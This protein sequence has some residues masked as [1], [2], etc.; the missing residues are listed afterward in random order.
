MSSSSW[1][2]PCTFFNTA[3]GCRNGDR[4]TFLHDLTVS[5]QQ[6]SHGSQHSYSARARSDDFQTWSYDVP[7]DSSAPRLGPD[8][9]RFLEKAHNLVRQ[10]AEKMQAVITRLSSEGGLHRINEIVHNI[11]QTLEN[12]IS[13]QITL[14]RTQLLRLFQILSNRDVQAS[15]IV[16]NS[17]DTIANFLFGFAGRRSLTIFSFV[18]RTLSE[19]PVAIGTKESASAL[20]T[21]STV[22]CKVMDLNGS[23]VIT[24]GFQP[25]L[26]SFVAC[27]AELDDNVER[28]S[29]TS[30]RLALE[31]VHRR[32]GIGKALPEAKAVQKA[33][34]AQPTF[35]LYHDAP[36]WLS[37]QGPR[38]DNDFERI[39][40]IQIMPTALE[41]RSHRVEYLPVMEA[42]QLHLAGAPGLLDRQFR[43]LREDTVGSLRDAVRN[44][45]NSTGDHQQAA[46]TYVYHNAELYDLSFHKFRGLDLKYGFEQPIEVRTLDAEKRRAWWLASRRLQFGA[47]VCL[48]D[49]QGSP[50]FC[51]VSDTGLKDDSAS[52]KRTTG[53][54]PDN[55]FGNSQWAVVTLSLVE[56]NQGTLNRLLSGFVTGHGRGYEMLIEFPG[57]LLPSFEPTLRALQRYSQAAE[58][59]PFADLLA[60]VSGNPKHLHQIDPP[61]Y[62]LEGSFQFDLSCILSEGHALSLSP[63]EYFDMQTL[64]KHSSLDE[65]QAGSLVAALSRKFALIQGPPGTGKSYT[66]VAIIK[67]LLANRSKAQ[68]GPIICVCNTNHAIDQV[69]EHLIDNGVNQVIRIGSRS[70]SEVLE[71]LNLKLVARELQQTQTEK[72]AWWES[73]NE[74]EQIL[75]STNKILQEYSHAERPENISLYLEIN[76]RAQ[77]KELFGGDLVDEEGFKEIHRRSR[78]PLQDWLN[79][80]YRGTNRLAHNTRTVD[81]LQRSSLHSMIYAER[82]LIYDHWVQGIR[83][84]LKVQIESAL[85]QYLETRNQSNKVSREVE[86]RC[87]QQA[88]VVGVTTSGLARVMDLLERLKSKV[89]I[90]EEAAEVLEAHN[91]ASFPPSVEHAILIGDHLQLRPQIQNFGLSSE[92]THGKQFSLDVSLFERLV[93]PLTETALRVPF[94]TLGIQRRMHPS[95]SMLVRSTCYPQLKDAYN[96]AEYPEVAGMRRRLFWFDHEHVEAGQD[97]DSDSLIATSHSNDFEVKI[98]AA[99]VSHLLKQG[100]YLSQDIAVLTPYLG[101]LRKLRQELSQTFVVIVGERDL[102]K[103]EAIEHGQDVSIQAAPLLTKTTLLNSMRVAKVDN[104]QGEEAKVV[105][106]SLVRCNNQNKCGFLRTPNRINVLLSRA[107]HGMYIIG[108]ARTSSH[109]EMWSTVI[110]ILHENGNFGQTLELECPRHPDIDIRIRTPDD[111]VVFAP[112]GGCNLKCNQRLSCGHACVSR[113]HSD[114]LH[115]AV[116]CLESCSRQ[117][118]GCKVHPCPEICGEPCPTKC[119]VTLHNISLPC[120]HTVQDLPC[121]EAQDLDK[122]Q[123][124][125][126][127]TWV[128]CS[129]EHIIQIPCYKRRNA[130]SIECTAQCG[131]YL[132]CGHICKRSCSQCWT[133]DDN[134]VVTIEHGSCQQPC[135]RPSTT[136]KHYCKAVCHGQAACPLCE[137]PCEVRC[138]HS[139]C[140][141]KCH[142]PCPP[143]AEERCASRC[144][145]QSCEMPC[146]VP[147]NWIPCSKRCENSLA[148]GHQCPSLCGEVCPTEAYCQICCSDTIKELQV[149]FIMGESYDEIDLNE[150][151]VILPRCGH[152]VTRSNMDGI[153][154]MGRH[155]DI[156]EDGRVLAI[157]SASLPFSSEDMHT[158]P[159]CRGSLRDLSRYGRI[160]R[161]ALLDEAS[162]RFLVWAENEYIH[163][164][165]SLC[166][167]KD[168]LS[169]IEVK[170]TIQ[171]PLQ[172]KGSRNDQFRTLLRLPLF[173]EEN[174]NAMQLRRNILRFVERVRKEELPYQKVRDMVDNIRRRKGV[175]VDL[176]GDVVTVKMQH[177]LKATSLLIQCDLA[178]LSAA[179]KLKQTSRGA[180][181]LVQVAAE[182]FIIDLTINRQDC[183]DL[184]AAAVTADLP[185]HQVEGHLLFAQFAALESSVADISKGHEASYDAHPE[186]AEPRQRTPDGTE[187][188]YEA[189]PHLEAAEQLCKKYPKATSGMPEE[190]Q[191][192]AK[193]LR[194]AFYENVTSEERRQVLAAMN[195]ELRGT[196]HWQV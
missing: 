72:R 144:P 146:G 194:G 130:K 74:M 40:Q 105:I 106:V 83:S 193:M 64:L 103:L 46:R 127:I 111:F 55:V 30:A 102:S 104:F 1:K 159:T 190:L 76:N 4:C 166:L 156:D 37:E 67:V 183:N 93:A 150:D 192:A 13:T 184:V 80:G 180:N 21:C 53:K 168:Q 92:N 196:G 181:P 122:A 94:S 42:S 125:H 120:G 17:L 141:R 68:L 35:K 38:H 136:C 115:Q 63:G 10:D 110:S 19:L 101:Q 49:S 112:E 175:V 15:L 135:D 123:C 161:R 124:T 157:K 79:H 174:R 117:V 109:V 7:R 56:L 91:I 153:L 134:E 65:A 47:L 81:E 73:K 139:T 5:N 52:D 32:L 82:R 6:P 176:P 167:E 20:E 34:S 133:T 62:C 3:R 28:L 24:E 98:T 33:R 113:C 27:L 84:K 129:C 8:L 186:S 14:F 59:L 126:P 149:D 154:D 97:G 182:D 88:H 148:C 121:H 137:S 48:L 60:P 128:L 2:R 165:E 195:T 188:R 116:R 87:L 114:T 77:F 57:V 95:I 162:K 138:I 160:V 51:S 26:K 44:I 132:P 96:V 75:K 172:L 78:K 89:L 142:E 173:P 163:L 90:I 31:R 185:A 39:D 36:G 151:P 140:S 107:K 85:D 108:N 191:V 147:C 171:S 152:L 18:A 187:L 86:L 169:A 131:I 58:D 177:H 70:K 158:C 25:I 170:R 22:L 118:Q 99:L 43:L 45:Q 71:K 29:L 61:A 23:A 178:I 11:D 179:I 12:P 9:S 54:S 143:C 119:Q 145:H 50:I 66:G 41:L 16:E 155:Y 69:L 164:V 189:F 100:T